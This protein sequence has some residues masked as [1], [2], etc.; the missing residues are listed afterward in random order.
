M[1]VTHLDPPLIL[2]C[3]SDGIYGVVAGGATSATSANFPFRG[4][5]LYAKAG[6]YQWKV[7]ANVTRVLVD[8]RG[9]GGSGAFG[10]VET[11]AGGGGGGGICSRICA[12]APGES[13]TVTVAAGGKAVNVVNTA[14]SWGG[15]SSFGSFCSATGGEG[16]TLFNG[17]GGG[18]GVG[19]DFNAS[20]G[21]GSPPVRNTNNSGAWGGPGGGGESIYA[22]SDVST[23]TQ[24][25]MGGG[26][27]TV[28][29][30]QPGADGCVFITY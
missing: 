8:I 4:R 1:T 3:L 18:M 29:A 5:A 19:G 20:L 10:P 14:G 15:T 9:G 16:G 12:V 28:I 25:G 6:T 26:G 22:A 30:S 7:P 27:R 24:P 17:A 11:G 13:I 2:A 21:A 23:P